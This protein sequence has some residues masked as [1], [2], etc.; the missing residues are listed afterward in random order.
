MRLRFVALLSFVFTCLFF[1]EYL[2]PL[3]WVDIPYDLAGYH[4]SLVDYAFLS[5][6]SGHF[7]QW[8]S[9]NYCGMSFVGNLQVA[10]FYP[11]IWL[12]FLA[13]IGRPRLYFLT[14]EILVLAHVW[15]A[16]LFCF[17]W[18]RRKGLRDLACALGAGVF[19][20]S[21]YLV[22]QLQHFGLVCAY[23]W[24]P[25]GLLSI[26]EASRSRTWRPL[27]KLACAAALCFLAGYPPT[28]AVFCICMITY[29][30]FS[31][32]WKVLPWTALALAFSMAIA[33]VQLLPTREA[34]TQKIVKPEYGDVLG[35]GIPNFFASYVIPNF[36]DFGLNVPVMKNWGGEYLYLGAPAIFGLLWL[37]FGRRSLRGHL[38]IVAVALVCFVFADNPHNIGWHIVGHLGIFA[39]IIRSYYF[40]AGLT[41]A[42]APLAAAGID[43]FLSRKSRSVPLWVSAVAGGLLAIWSARLLWA[44]LPGGPG[45]PPGWPGAIYPLVMLVLFLGSLFVF[46]ASTGPQR[47]WLATALLLAVGV[48]YKV[49]GTSKR[50]N[51]SKGSVDRFMASARFSGIEDATLDEIMRHPEFRVATGSI[52]LRAPDFRHNGLPSPQG[53]DPLVPA[54][55]LRE[56]ILPAHPLQA[57]QWTFMLDPANEDLLRTL[58]VRYMIASDIGPAFPKLRNNV[59]YRPVGHTDFYFKVFELSNALPAYRWEG[60]VQVTTWRAG[61]REFVVHSTIGGPFILIEQFLPGWSAFVDGKAVPITRWNHAFQSIQVPAGDHRLRFAFRSTGLLVGAVISVLSLLALAYAVTR[62]PHSSTSSNS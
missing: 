53:D 21:G 25:V 57:Q 26:D 40:L 5:L 10:L 12:M 11:P 20:Y 36:F 58:G 7:P 39:Q 45:F 41:L 8:D 62:H 44:W 30:L 34:L 49:F 29:A 47:A 27:W 43:H 24:F 33:M 59:D 51:A 3:R 42:A 17:I 6:K 28:F 16:F 9:A 31:R 48:D 56:V 18:L 13:N 50:F 60:P 19:A 61:R 4:Y 32:P 38:P 22:L 1:I 23:V 37:V 35:G 14:L 54:Q 52:E 46:R 2:P 15:L 55:Y